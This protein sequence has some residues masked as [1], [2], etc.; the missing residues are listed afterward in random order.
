MFLVV[1]HMIAMI[2]W[3]SYQ[4]PACVTLQKYTC[5]TGSHACN[6]KL[7][8]P[9]KEKVSLTV[10]YF[11]FLAFHYNLLALK[12]CTDNSVWTNFASIW[13]HR[14]DHTYK[15]N[16]ALLLKARRL[17]NDYPETRNRHDT[18]KAPANEETSETLLWK[19]CFPG[20]QT[21]KHLLKKQNVAKKRPETFFV[22]RK[23]NMFPRQMFPVRANGETFGETTYM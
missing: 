7:T 5:P 1:T 19:H 8:S 23:Q 3:I 22:S 12:A 10:I 15:F 14:V 18:L 13:S 17:G 11:A 20:A 2:S 9:T 16:E 21:G 4:R 6:N